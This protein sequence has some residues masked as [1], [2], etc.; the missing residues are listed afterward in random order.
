MAKLPSLELGA[1]G[2]ITSASHDEVKFV[3]TK[4]DEIVG[5]ALP[6][7]VRDQ[8]WR[9]VNAAIGEYERDRDR[10]DAKD[11]VKLIRKFKLFGRFD[12]L[13]EDERT[14][15]DQFAWAYQLL[16]NEIDR[17]R[18]IRGEEGEGT[19]LSLLAN[20]A[21]RNEICDAALS[22]LNNYTGSVGRPKG[23]WYDAFVKDVVDIVVSLGI[24]PTI[25]T[26][27]ITGAHMGKF[28]EFVMCVE[29]LFE[30]AMRSQ[31]RGACAKRLERGKRRIQNG[32]TSTDAENRRLARRDAILGATE[33]LVSNFE[34]AGRR[35]QN[36]DDNK[37][38]KY[39]SPWLL[40][41]E[42]E[43]RDA[44]DLLLSSRQ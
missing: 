34:N 22:K 38:G 26:C 12:E 15:Y 43:C 35:R 25:E 23:R 41:W 5:T 32:D 40:R 30:P 6:E 39:P 10:V 31:S 29:K 7:E 8:V 1:R 4:L 13:D 17:R 19:I 16:W 20:R 18:L 24:R 21:V 3:Y 37:A 36:N 11:V 2:A 44:L 27:R 9:A 42:A 33:K 28:I 14:P